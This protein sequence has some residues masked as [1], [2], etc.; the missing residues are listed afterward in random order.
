M[1]GCVSYFLCLLLFL[2]LSSSNTL[3][4]PSV[5]YPLCHSDE[6]SALLQFKHSFSI[7]NSSDY[8]FY[9]GCPPPK[10]DSWEN[11]TNCCKWSGVTCDKMTGH[12]IGLNLSCGRLVGRIH[13]NSSLFLLGH[14]QSLNFSYNDFRGSAIPSDLGKLVHLANLEIIYSNFSGHIPPDISYLSKLDSLIL[15]SYS[16]DA[17]RLETSTMKRIVTNLTNLKE[18][19][20]DGVDM[21][22]VHNPLSLTNL[23]SSTSLSLRFCQ[24]KG[25]IKDKFFYLTKLKSLDLSD[26]EN[27]T[28]F[29]PKSNW[30]SSLEYLG[31]S[32]TNFSIDFPHLTKSMKS[33]NTLYLGSCKILGWNPT[34]L[35]NLTQIT[36]LYLS[37]HN[38]GGQ[39]PWSSLNLNKLIKL[40]LSGNNFSGQLPQ[41]Y[42]YNLSKSQPIVEP[43]PLNL[44]FLDLSNN[45]LQ[46]PIPRSLFQLVNLGWLD[47]SSN[48]LS[49]V[50]ELYE[51]S[52]LT[53]I[54]YL[55][56]SFNSLSLSRS[57]IF[58][59]HTLPSIWCLSL[60]S[61]NIKEFPYF[62]RASKYLYTLE[63]SFNQIEGN[64]PNWLWNVSRDSLRYLSLSHNFLT[65]IQQLPWKSLFYLDL[66][67]NLLQG[68]LPI[69]PPSTRIFLVSNNQL[70]GEIPSF[71]CNLNSIEIL[72]LSNNSMSGK[73][74]PCLGNFSDSLSVLNLGMNKLHGMIPLSFERGNSLRNL[75][76]NGNQ[77]EG[78]LS[79]SLL[80]CKKLEVLDIGNNKINGTFPYWLGSLP[81]LQV[82]IL[83]S[84]RFH[85]SISGSL[86]S[87]LPFRRL[88][89]MD[90]SDNQFSGNLPSNYFQSFMAMMDAQREKMKYMG[91]DYYQDSV[92]VTI[93]GFSI[94][95]VKIQTILTTID[96][97]KNNFEGEIP[98][99]IGKLKSLKGLNLSHNKLT[100]SIPPS[101]ANL[102]NLEW[103]DLTWNELVSGIPQQLTEITFLAVFNLSENRLVGPIP[104]GN[105]FETFE[106]SSYRENSGLCGFPSSKICNSSEAPQPSQ[107]KNLEQK[108]EFD[109]WKVAAMGYAC[110][111]VFGISM[112]YVLLSKEMLVVMIRRR[113]GGERWNRVLR[114]FQG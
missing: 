88:R 66:R 25:N 46:G 41:M 60:S 47:L 31:L 5:S 21:S 22:S 95:L 32:S 72:D 74:P 12:V 67:S 29:L 14:L 64:I 77:L 86:K 20:L 68:S 94:E 42:S 104:R 99:L 91:D 109:F 50:V 53:N 102:S 65:G 70:S 23:S 75:N 92:V 26:N 83:R 112:G 111:L 110:G 107:A 38:L 40:D 69:P 59:N 57:K 1:T 76:L 8:S 89:I 90:L 44:E 84:N 96:L 71:V 45:K 101:L 55:N 103:L 82:L 37:F 58:L 105:Q 13:S 15:S 24:L 63:L 51:F 16:F 97:S 30:S 54:Q 4:S 87:K 113:V 17:L 78:S 79:Q 61:C 100:G 49:G 43:L 33:L 52:K 93:K 85:G 98:E 108:N 35:S 10:T 3:S 34:L 28:G 11:G 81:M 7:D 114:R 19:S 106:N 73:I 9:Y 80:N 18:L 2:F 36:S 27:L 6:S 62:I 48:N 56:L 39:I